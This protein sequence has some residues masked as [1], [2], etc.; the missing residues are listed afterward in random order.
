MDR[1]HRRGLLQGQLVL[2][3]ILVISL[4]GIAQPAPATQ[5]VLVQGGS[6]SQQTSAIQAVGG[7]IQRQFSRFETSVAHVSTTQI[8]QLKAQGL[9]VF[10]DQTVEASAQTTSAP[11]T[12]VM[13]GPGPKGKTSPAL[14]YPSIVTGA[15]ALQRRGIDGRG[16]TVAVI[17]SGLPAI[18]RPERWQ[19]I[20]N[21]TARYSQGSRF[22]VYKDMLASSQITNSSDPY[23]H[24][25]HVFATLAD[26]RALPPEYG[27]A[28]V[29]IAPGAN[30]VVVRA[31][32][33][34]GK[35]SYSTIIAA[36][37]WV[38]ENADVYNIRVL[39]L[40]LQA[41]VV[42]PYWYDP[43][44]Q[45][46]MHA[47][48]EGI[49]VVA[50]AGNTGSNPATIMAPANVPY[51]VSVGAIRPAV[52]N[53]NGSDT[54]A[55]YSSAGPTESRFVK[56]DVVIAGSRVIAPLPAD[57]LLANSSAAGLVSE[58]AQLQWADLKTSQQLN[59]YALSG[60]SMAAAEVSGIVA[61]LIQDEPTLSNNQIKARLT[62]TAQVAT[63]DNGQ[64]AY[65][66]W[67]QGAGKVIP[68]A[69][70]DGSNTGSANAGMDLTTDLIVSSNPDDTSN[71]YQGTTEYD[72]TSN[73]F[74]DSTTAYS[75][76]LATSYSTWAG[77]YS[78]WA[79][80][81]L[82]W[83][84][85]Y[86][87]WAGSYSTWAGSYNTWA[88]SYSTWAGSYSTWAGSYST[89]AGNNADAGSLNSNINA[90]SLVSD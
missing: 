20:N 90:G 12:T 69:V 42:S 64:A 4:L 11:A 56:P 73:T 1:E 13:A 63:L 17:D 76:T 3:M 61:L 83:A 70:V 21:T 74:S 53:D 86:S 65:S 88:G 62:G 38:I 89:W 29:G 44:N 14:Q 9:R 10:A 23:G 2:A 6:L 54:I 49:T 25:T 40:S 31:L 7:T 41:E 22:L 87:T 50:A 84:G 55:A 26:N 52:Y 85:S 82:T 45:A 39:N 51:I 47:W 57:S 18:E 67:Q 34:Q 8:E 78:T 43:M 71:H 16:V 59:Y 48:N 46:V 28:K 36:I 66:M 60:T 5:Q 77:S 75:S 33:S 79:G 19:R 68:T 81:Y 32:D 24:G 35:A 15:D 58:R 80:S 30:Y 37:D 27:T 72:S